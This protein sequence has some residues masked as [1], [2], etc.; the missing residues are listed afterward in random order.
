MESLIRKRSARILSVLVFW[1]LTTGP[2]ST[3]EPAPASIGV[4]CGALLVKIMTS[5]ALQLK[6]TQWDQLS[7][8]TAKVLD[9]I[10]HP[11]IRRNEVWLA[12]LVYDDKSI[13][14]AEY[15]DAEEDYHVIY[16]LSSGKLI[17][18]AES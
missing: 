14:L 15:V 13:T 5:E 4:E 18:Q 2:K 1:L 10:M 9:S 11:A 16:I 3:V 6:K 8:T 17:Y 7:E 12:R